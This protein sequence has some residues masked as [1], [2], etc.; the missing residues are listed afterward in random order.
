MTDRQPS[1]IQKVPVAGASGLLG[2]EILK[3]L[4]QNDVCINLELTQFIYAG[5][6]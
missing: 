3:L 6:L 5:P 1:I 2:F 4:W